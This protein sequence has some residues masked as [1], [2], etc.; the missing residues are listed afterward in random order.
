MTGGPQN[1]RNE[2]LSAQMRR[3]MEIWNRT[4]AAATGPAGAIGPTSPTS[5]AVNATFANYLRQTGA[6]RPD[7]RTVFV[8]YPY[9]F[10]E[11]DYRGVFVAVGAEYNVTFTFAD[12]QLTNKHIL[13]KIETMMYDAAFSLF[14]ITT[15]NP[16]VALEHGIAYGNSLDYYI[17]FDPTQGNPD[18]LSDVRGI[19]R[20]QYTSH[21]E[22]KTRLSKLMRDQF[23]AP[24]GEQEEKGKDLAGQIEDLRHSVPDLVR[25]EPGQ[26]IGGIASSLG[27]PIEIAQ[28]VVRPLV[29]SELDTSGV[30]RGTR[31]YPVGE[32]PPSDDELLD[33]AGLAEPE[34]PAHEPDKSPE[35]S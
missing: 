28:M 22:L 12:E 8:A 2:E 24:A 18:V 31:Y 11:D 15:W 17:L 32:A 21:T 27:V 13:E 1:P 14:D 35:A 16:N 5:A 30:R 19:D 26:Q 9:T 23:G 7:N 29:G 4:R 33:A 20:I 6:A 25:A 3:S 10:P 34:T